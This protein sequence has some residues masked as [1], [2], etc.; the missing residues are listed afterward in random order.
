MDLMSPSGGPITPHPMH[1][2]AQMLGSLQS[3]PGASFGKQ[4]PDMAIHVAP[5]SAANYGTARLTAWGT[6][7]MSVPGHVAPLSVTNRQSFVS[8]GSDDKSTTPAAAG[9][10]QQYAYAQ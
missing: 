4:S 8:F 5:A 9:A 3:D 1:S 6:H 7:G 10:Q 2:A